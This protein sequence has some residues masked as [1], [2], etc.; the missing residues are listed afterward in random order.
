MRKRKDRNRQDKTTGQK[1]TGTIKAASATIAGVAFLRNT[2]TAHRLVSEVFPAVRKT[3]RKASQEL[4]EQNRKVKASDIERAFGKA[5]G[6]S[7]IH[8]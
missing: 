6:L 7:L 8:I 2:E 4:Y 3:Y 5:I 1:I